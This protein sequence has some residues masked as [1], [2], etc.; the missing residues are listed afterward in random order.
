MR[1]KWTT[2]EDDDDY[3]EAARGSHAPRVWWFVRL[4]RVESY[5]GEAEY[6]EIGC[7]YWLD[8]SLVDLDQILAETVES[9]RREVF[10]SIRGA[11]GISAMADDSLLPIPITDIAIAHQLQM[12]G[13]RAPMYDGRG[14]SRRKLIAEGRRE[15]RALAGDPYAL[16]R[17]MNKPVNQVGATAAEFMVNDLGSAVA[18]GIAN[19]DPQAKLI[20]IIQGTLNP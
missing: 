5:V 1:L 7:D 12:N 6:K 4:M 14:N 9:A 2:L 17:R 8:V 16:T 11:Y 15:A 19:G 10:D 18:R 20:A 13:S 3:V